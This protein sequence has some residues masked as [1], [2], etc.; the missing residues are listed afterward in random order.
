MKTL[1]ILLITITS[2]N[3]SNLQDLKTEELVFIQSEEEYVY[4]EKEHEDALE[5]LIDSS[6]LDEYDL[7]DNSYKGKEFKVTYETVTDI[8]EFEEEYK[9]RTIT[10]LILIE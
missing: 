8:D 1:F 9:V 7:T 4:F 3:F 10:K 5:F 6:V 2:L